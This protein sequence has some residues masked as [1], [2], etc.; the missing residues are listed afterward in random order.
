MQG[1]SLHRLVIEPSLS[2]SHFT[3]SLHRSPCFR[4]AGAS[5]TQRRSP[6]RVL[7]RATRLSARRHMRR[8]CLEEDQL[9]SVQNRLEESQ[10]RNSEDSDTS[11]ISELYLRIF[12]KPASPVKC[13]TC[14]YPFCLRIIPYKSPL[15]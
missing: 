8:A 1:P 7:S 11:D 2:L 5:E 15:I 3:T 10:R 14:A 4:S 13:A 6:T 12:G 9:R